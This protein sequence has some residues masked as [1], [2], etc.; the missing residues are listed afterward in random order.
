MGK[1]GIARDKG[2]PSPSIDHAECREAKYFYE[3]TFC[4]LRLFRRPELSHSYWSSTWW[5][6]IKKLNDVIEVGMD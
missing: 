4:A 5:R 6:D 1:T 2:C 3:M